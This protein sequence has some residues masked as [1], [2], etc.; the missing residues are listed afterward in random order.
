MSNKPNYPFAW[1]KAWF[2]ACISSRMTAWRCVESQSLVATLKLVDSREEQSALE[3]ML[4]ASKPA[5]PEGSDGLHYLLFT[6]FRYTSPYQ[7]RFR[8]PNE[9]GVWYGADSIQ[10]VCAETAYWRNRFILDSSGLSKNADAV[11]TRHTLFQACVDGLELNLTTPPWDAGRAHW[12]DGANY[13]LTQSLAADAR[14]S[15]LQWIRYESVRSPGAHCAAVLH[16]RALSS[17]NPFNLHEWTCRATRARVI[18][19]ELGGPG[20]Y[21]WDF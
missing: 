19:S 15:G 12:T 2:D 18:L 20:A 10:T 16:P 11:V 17:A 14:M 7:S 5:R 1:E 3:D 4:E 6:P 9:A 13:D 8:R 21:S